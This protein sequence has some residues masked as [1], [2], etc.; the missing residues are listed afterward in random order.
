MTYSV[1]PYLIIILSAVFGSCVNAI[2]FKSKKRKSVKNIKIFAELM[3]H[4]MCG[5]II[6]LVL[7]NFTKNYTIL[8]SVTLIGS[9]FGEI[10]IKYSILMI[11]YYLDKFVK[12]P[13]DLTDIKE[14][15]DKKDEKEK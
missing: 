2:N 4:I 14:K 13:I 10:T 6:G 15:L 3:T 5:I 8:I 12:I 9:F 7:M 11:L 1:I